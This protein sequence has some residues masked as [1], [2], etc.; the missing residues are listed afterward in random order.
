MLPSNLL[1]VRTS[2]GLIKPAYISMD[3]ANLEIAKTIIK[4]FEI[5]ITKKKSEILNEVKQYENIGFDYRFI[6]GLALILERRCRF[7]A[8]SRL[9]SQSIRRLVFEEANRHGTVTSEETRAEILEKIAEHLDVA[10]DDVE[11]SLYGDLEDELIL[12]E[13]YPLSPEDLLKQY[14]LSLTQT[15]LFKSISIE[16]IAKSN[17]KNIFRKIKHL[18]L[19]YSAEAKPEEFRI[20]VEGSL[21]L[22]KL[23]ERYGTS[24]AKLLP[25]IIKGEGWRIKADI[26]K[27]GEYGRRILQLILNSN[28]V[29]DLLKPAFTEHSEASV[30]DSSVEEKFS[31]DFQSLNLGWKLIREPEPLISG[32]HVFIPDFSLEKD[33]LKI[34]LEIIGFW[35]QEYLERKIKKLKEL[36][37]IDLIIAIDMNL[38]C[39]QLKLIEAKKIIYFNKAVP[40]KPLVNLLRELEEKNQAQQVMNLKNIQIKLEGDII[41]LPRLADN[42]GVSKTAIT[43]ILTERDTGNYMLI[44]DTM[45]SRTKLDFIDTKL[46]ML[47]EKTLSN[48]TQLIE[49]EGLGNPDQILKALGYKVKWNGLDMEKATLQKQ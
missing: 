33:S 26:V 34:Y 11:E 37:G 48:A 5:N 13:F 2:R 49:L 25:E 39:S 44:G 16:F 22:F 27:E 14:N 45:I 7:E 9:N 30:F 1:I 32:S 43:K 23:T 18:G 19:M 36:I 4:N 10:V 41:E 21:S 17:W 6:R 47:Q 15:L 8:K 31:R 12:K 24:L 29:G 20:T 35:T 28:D 40:L 3:E 46:S 38:L 42:L